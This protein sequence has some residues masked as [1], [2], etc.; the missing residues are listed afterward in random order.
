MNRKHYSTVNSFIKQVIDIQDQKS[1]L[2]EKHSR[3]K[4]SRKKSSETRPGKHCDT[5]KDNLNRAL[6]KIANLEESINCNEGIKVINGEKNQIE[7]V[8]SEIK[9]QQLK[10]Q[11]QLN[12][13]GKRYLQDEITTK[14]IVENIKTLWKIINDIKSAVTIPTHNFR[15]KNKEEYNINEHFFSECKHKKLAEKTIRETKSKNE[16]MKS[17]LVAYNGIEVN[18]PKIDVNTSLSIY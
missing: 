9:N 14:K 16:S 1:E 13:M 6:V 15:E 2:G 5:I 11:V 7:S 10:L 12:E 17:N 18:L 4:A 8:I 3:K